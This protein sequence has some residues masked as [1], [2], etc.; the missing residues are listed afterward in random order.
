MISQEEAEKR[1][2]LY[3]KNKCSFLF[4]LNQGGWY[5]YMYAAYCMM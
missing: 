4:N 3:D 5:T 2:K 1:G